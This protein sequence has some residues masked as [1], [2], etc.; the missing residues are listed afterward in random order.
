M[1]NQ[2]SANPSTMEVTAE[3][4]VPSNEAIHIKC[5]PLS[6]LVYN[7]TPGQK[8]LLLDRGVWSSQAITF[9]AVPFYPANPDYL[10]TIKGF[11]LIIEQHVYTI[12]NNIWHDQDTMFFVHKLVN[13][14]PE[15]D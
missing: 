1:V 15:Q 10:F 8:N 13:N 7:L 11:S 4:Y 6:F 9:H 5:S 3:H 12:V 2:V 14:T